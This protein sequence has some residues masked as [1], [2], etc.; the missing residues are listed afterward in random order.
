MRF[1]PLNVRLRSAAF[2][3]RAPSFASA[4]HATGGA[5]DVRRQRATT[6]TRDRSGAGGVLQVEVH[7]DR[8][9]QGD[10]ADVEE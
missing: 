7:Y 6:A 9:R 3:E 8:A 2:L 5:R 4:L 10:Q 1:F